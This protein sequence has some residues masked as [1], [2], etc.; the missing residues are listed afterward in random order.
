M[1]K[2]LVVVATVFIGVGVL[3]LGGVRKYESSQRYQTQ[4]SKLA[5]ISSN[6]QKEL[7]NYQTTTVGVDTYGKQNDVVINLSTFLQ[8][9]LKERLT[10]TDGKSYQSNRV[11]LQKII[12]DE[13]FFAPGGYLKDDKD[14]FG[15]SMTDVLRLKSEVQKVSV[16]NQNNNR[17]GSF[18]VLVDSIPY[19]DPNTLKY[20]GR[21]QHT[22][23]LFAVETDGAVISSIKLEKGLATY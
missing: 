19:K 11:A 22:Y 12:K 4:V 2:N 18:Y 23:A 20:K 17:P 14:S 3:T 10:F 7:T 9:T 15:D 16:F 5:D 1:R 13:T 21:L 8:E 6:Y